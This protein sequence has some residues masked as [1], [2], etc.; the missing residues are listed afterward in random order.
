VEEKGAGGFEKHF[1]KLGGKFMVASQNFTHEY[2]NNKQFKFENYH[3]RNKTHLLNLYAF[4]QIIYLV[5]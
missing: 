3:C 4:Q 1:P 2:H 5:P